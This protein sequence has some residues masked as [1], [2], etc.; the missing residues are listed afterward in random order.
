MPYP[1]TALAGRRVLVIGGAGLIGSRIAARLRAVG[2]RPVVLC[3]LRP[4]G[5]PRGSGPRHP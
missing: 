4:S 1:Y 2:A 5:C 3:S